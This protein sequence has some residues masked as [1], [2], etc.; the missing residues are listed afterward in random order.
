MFQSSSI[1]SSQSELDRL[2]RQAVD[3]GHNVVMVHACVDMLDSVMEHQVALVEDAQKAAE[4]ISDANN[5][6][7]KAAENVGHSVRDTLETVGD[8]ATRIRTTLG[9]SQTIAEWV[10]T[11]D[12]TMTT[13][14]QTLAEM[15]SRANAIGNIA[16]QVNMLAI[17]ARIEAA[18]SG[19]AGRGFAVVAQE[20]DRLSHQTAETTE[21]ITVSIGDLTGSIS[22]LRQDSGVI[23]K[24]ASQTLTDNTAIDDALG[25]IIE[26]VTRSEG[27]VSEI[28]TKAADVDAANSS[29]M[30]VFS[31]VKNGISQTA[32]HLHEARQQLGVVVD[33]SESM[34]QK[35]VEMGGASD[36]AQMIELVQKTAADMADALEKAVDRGEISIAQLMNFTYQPIP[37]TAP[38]QHLAPFT[39]LTDRIFPLFQEAVLQ[40]NPGVTFCAAV[41]RNGYLPT[42]NR[43]FSKRQTHDTEWN[44]AHS[45]NR[46]IFNDR[47][48]LGAGKNTKPFLL[49]IY[50]RDMGGGEHRMMKD[51]SAPIIV[52]GRHWGGLRLAYE[53]Q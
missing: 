22:R 29:F 46:R 18:R 34:V 42:H 2:A 53:Y 17:N 11:L 21:G 28:M 15:S 14:T 38:Q 35:T 5:S 16:Q 33:I 48:G 4:R 3:L 41:D 7:R 52:N 12:A 44:A 40:A 20:I 19:D 47:V 10:Q 49:Q 51:I 26:K 8:S 50:R 30:P 24:A 31:T 32:E 39:E 9:K 13:I 1:S 37:G 6:V 45:R 27:S 25:Q 43:K 23:A 36:D